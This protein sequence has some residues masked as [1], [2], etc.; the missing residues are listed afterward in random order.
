M[1]DEQRQDQASLYVLRMLPPAEALAFARELEHDPEL[2]QLVSQLEDT[3]STVALAAPM[4]LPPTSLRSRVLA[5]VRGDPVAAGATSR[6]IM[7]WIPWT[8]AAGL[9]LTAGTFWYEARTLR[10]GYTAA[11][12]ELAQLRQRDPFSGTQI[13]TLI[14]PATESDK[15]VGFVFFD[16]RKQEGMV[17][18]NVP[19]AG[20]GKDYQLWIIDPATGKPVSA[21]ILRPS[22]DGSVTFK[23]ERP[24]PSADTFAVSLEPTGGS[25]QPTGPVI[26][27]GKFVL[28]K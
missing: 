16:T 20:A 13:A 22:A 12:H 3:A 14:P 1:I 11:Q 25:N 19:Q 10:E 24:L 26:L 15:P 6:G 17:K 4:R 2:Q 8:L 5:A 27:Q 28:E 9:A 7:D 21:G 18:L 23:P